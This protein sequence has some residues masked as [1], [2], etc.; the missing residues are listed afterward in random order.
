MREYTVN[1]LVVRVILESEVWFGKVMVL[2]S[3]VN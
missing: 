2:F 1:W 3:R